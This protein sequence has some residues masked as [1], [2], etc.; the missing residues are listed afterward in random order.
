MSLIFATYFVC[1]NCDKRF[2]MLEAFRQLFFLFKL[3]HE[4]SID[5]MY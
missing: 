4:K 2:P 5:K 3:L 1:K